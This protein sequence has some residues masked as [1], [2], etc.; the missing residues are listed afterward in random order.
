MPCQ[1]AE[2]S[3]FAAVRPLAQNQRQEIGRLPGASTRT[4]CSNSRRDC[5]SGSPAL[6]TPTATSVLYINHL[7]TFRPLYEV[8]H[9][10]H[11]IYWRLR[12]DA[13]GVSS[14][15]VNNQK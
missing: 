14:V 9:Q 13:A 4:T 6:N 15:I 1:S 5:S 11:S 2:A 10:R 8:H 7:F 3:S 12:G